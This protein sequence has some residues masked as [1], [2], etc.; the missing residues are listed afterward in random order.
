MKSVIRLLIVSAVCL[1]AFAATASAQYMYLDVNGDGVNTA[2]DVLT[3]SS[4]GVDIYLR[5][6]VNKNGSAAVCNASGSELTMNSYEFMVRSSG[7]AMTLGAWTDGLGFPGGFGDFTSGTDAYH[8]R[9]GPQQVAGSYKLG[10]LALS[11][12][13]TGAVLS[14]VPSSTVN[15]PGFTSFGSLCEGIDLDNTYKLGTDWVD[16]DGTHTSGPV[17]ANPVITAPATVSG[18]EAV[19]V[20]IT[21]SAIDPDADPVT[22]SQTNNASFMTGLASNGPSANPSITLSGTPNLSESGVYTVNWIA[23]DN[24][25]GSATATTVLTV[26]N[27]NRPPVITAPAN[28]G[29]AEGIAISVTASATD[30]DDDNVGLSQTNNAPFFLAA[31]SA[32]PSSDPTITLSGTPSYIEAGSYT[33]NWTANDFLGGSDTASTAVT[34]S[35]TDRTV[36]LNP[37]ADIIVAE[38]ATASTPVSATDPDGDAISLTP[39]GFPAFAVLNPPTSGVGSVSTT[40]TASP[41]VGDAAGSPYAVSIMASAGTTS[42]THNFQIIV[43]GAGDSPPVL[44][45][46]GAKTIAEGTSTNY[47]ISAT[48]PNGD[49]ILLSATLPAFG[50]LNLPTSGAGT[51]TTT[52]TLAP[53]LSDAGS[54]TGTVTATANGLVDSET[55]N[56]T[57]T[58]S[59]NLV[60]TIT[61]PPTA[62]V[63]EGQL[64][65]FTVSASDG[66]NDPLT[67]TAVS[68]PSGAT[69]L[70]NGNGTGAFSWTPNFTQAGSF[71]V[72]FNVSDGN[73]GTNSATT[74]ITVDNVNRCPTAD[75]GG[76]YVGIINVAVSV[77]GS[78]SSDPD[79]N[80]LTYSWT[81][82]DGGVGTGVSVSH[83]YIAAGTFDVG[84]TVNDGICE[85]VD[86]TTATISS[87]LS[88]LVFTTGGNNTTNL[89]SGKP[90]TCVQIEPVGGAFQISDVDL[91]SIKMI[92]NGT[93]SV[94]E[95]PAI[96]DKTN[97]DGDKNANG[98][99]EIRACFSKDDLRLLFGD[100]PSGRNTVTVMI[101]GNLLTGGS[102]SGTLTLIVKASGNGNGKGQKVTLSPN[103][104]NP[105]TT[106]SFQI[107]TPGRVTVKV[108]DLNGRLVKT[109]FD[110]THDTGFQDVT[111]N[112]TSD[113]GMKV[114]SGVY[115]FRLDTPSGRVVKAATVLK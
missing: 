84:L 28:E 16:V 41:V 63:N 37:I 54:Y 64:L 6:N 69:F 89:N 13:A 7:A 60:P 2:A 99:S 104:L 42:D 23:V 73:G 80:A 58:A 107:S 112:G 20:L 31:S 3:S 79:G 1:S 32:G 40:V 17:N 87:E 113:N 30:P 108:F 115:F 98:I 21:G 102:F 52:F 92:S 44:A 86:A 4:T 34:I 68:L 50:T 93:G 81:F 96:G 105:E 76:P 85:D 19:A 22:L 59:A 111:W 39:S 25:T 114:A 49:T 101:E 51:V 12:I 77:S 103:P 9:S 10:R 11:G 61:A 65:T 55:F 88:T 83:T 26:A 53:G 97:G 90:T 67:L 45:A 66:D 47:P 95:I 82:G 74:V 43:S 33:I 18:T 91:S 24:T 38:G 27:V 78:G 71:T 110:G 72:V 106:L 48:D 100:L 14:I 5:T 75:A 56:I 62:T 46:I 109:L 57:V 36:Q 29:G 70:D 15:P 94:S 35:N 8:G